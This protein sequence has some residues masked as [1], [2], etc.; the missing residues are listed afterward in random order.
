MSLRVRLLLL[1]LAVLVPTAASFA[2][3][4]RVT[5]HRETA[6]GQERLR[7][8]T[9][10][11][12][13][14]VDREISKRAAI[15][16]TLGALQSIAD[17]DFERFHAT[18]RLATQGTG[19]W[20]VLVDHDDQFVNTRVPYGELLP[21]R[22]WQPD[23]GLVTGEPKVSNL[24][25]GPVT[26][27][28]VL[29]VF[30]PDAHFK[31]VRYN[32]GVAFTPAPLQAIITDQRLPEGWVAAVIDREYVVVAR[33]PDPQL[34]QGKRAQPSLIEALQRHPEGLIESVTLDGREVLAFYSRSPVYG[35]AFVI[36]VPR[37]VLAA[38][39]RHAAW[40]AV[41]SATLLVAFGMLLAAW[42]AGRLRQGEETQRLLVTLNDATRDVR[43]ASE[44][45]WNIA[46]TLGR[47][48]HVDRCT[49]AEVDET[50]EHLIVTRDYTRGMASVAGTHRLDAFGPALVESLSR[51]E[52]VAITDVARDH[53]T[54]I[55]PQTLD[56]FAQSGT[57]A[58]LA[59][60]LVK[61]GH[62]AAL[63]MLTQRTPRRWT[64]DEIALSRQAAQRSWF[65][66]ENARAEAELRESRDVLA[67]AMRGGR[68]GAW[69]RNLLTERVWWSGELEEIF[70]LPA[71]G[72]QGTTDRFRALVHDEDRGLLDKAVRQAIETREDYRVEFRFRH[73]SGSWRWMEGRGRAVYD[74]EGRPTMLYGIGIDITERKQADEELMRLNARLSEADRRKDEFLATLAHELRNP[75]APIVNALQ[76]MQLRGGS[77]D[78]EAAWARDII[79][80]QVRQLT[81]LVDDL[82][83]IA[84]ITRGKVQ[85]QRA[86]VALQSVV[87]EAIEAARPLIDAAGHRLDVDLPGEPLW[88]EADAM[89]LTQ[90]LLNLL[91]NAAKYTPAGGHIAIVAKRENDQAWLAVRDSGIGIEPAQIDEV[92]QMFAQVAPALERAHGGLGIGLALARALVKLHGGKLEAQSEGPG[93]GSE[94]VVRL[95]L[96]TGTAPAQT[97]SPA[98]TQGVARQALRVLVVDDN[99]DAAQSLAAVL[100]MEGHTVATAYDGLDALAQV[101]SF[102]PDVVMLDIGMPGMNGYEVA[103]RIRAEPGGSRRLL[104]A[105][106]GW[107][108]QEDKRRA[109]DAGFDRHVTKPIDPELFGELFDQARKARAD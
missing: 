86:R 100:S 36:G 106:T 88:L 75:L 17:G 32:V 73:A 68:M 90:V 70:G 85:L 109:A 76:I 104:V 52:C 87:R 33:S 99:R 59:V 54:T 38:A 24:R 5:Y 21:K 107:G 35:W 63:L 84:R 50:G 7:E 39:A 65:A 48:F 60:P 28:P 101:A 67:L 40:Q 80:R 81:R 69:S 10:A 77:R 103:R 26:K 31:P 55:R 46:C 93:R 66:V 96:A 16:R 25:T 11:L 47:H 72:F 71:G 13:L 8:T 78:A 64:R 83:D 41:A 15:A 79:E 18:A 1:M 49:Y 56:A 74:A 94:F 12:A 43:S 9:R 57:A 51:G 98:F 2:W 30:A 3:L 27:M 29:A 58:L 62:F 108:Q 61:R 97:S 4:V 34:W 92:F 91:N 44:A 14:L 95:P 37:A 19:D 6:S 20:V 53:R 102:E 42:A 23:T 89:R 22:T 82:L 105:L 45:E